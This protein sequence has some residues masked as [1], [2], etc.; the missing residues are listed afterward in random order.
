MLAEYRCQ[1]E[2][3]PLPAEEQS[4]LFVFRTG[5]PLSYAAVRSVFA[6]LRELADIRRPASD[7]WQPRIHDLRATFAVHRLLAWYRQGA[8]LQTRLPLLATYLGHAS[9]SGTAC[10]LSMIPEL[11]SE[12]SLRFERY[13]LSCQ[14]GNHD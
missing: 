7:R 9:V 11:L 13:A 2:Y 8:N 4:Q 14:E 1:R 5:K 3:L 10:Y 6:Q 12:A